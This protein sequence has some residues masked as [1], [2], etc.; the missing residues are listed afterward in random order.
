MMARLRHAKHRAAAWA[1]DPVARVYVITLYVLLCAVAGGGWL[2]IAHDERSVCVVQ[3]RGLPAGHHLADAMNSI[4]ALL[5]LTPTTKAER[6]AA[7]E[8]PR[9]VKVIEGQL[10]A[11]L[12][13]YQ[14][15]EAK[16]PQTR[17]C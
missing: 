16:Q 10:T 14:A 4:H 12:A 13:A 8:T 3:R 17:S 6:L 1:S 9:A 7:A 5:T 15:A 11:S 2:K